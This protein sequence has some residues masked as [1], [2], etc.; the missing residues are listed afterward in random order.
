MGSLMAGWSSPFADP[1]KGFH[2]MCDLLIVSV[3]L[4][5]ICSS[6]YNSWINITCT[7]QLKRNKSLTKEEID[8]FRK[9]HKT[10]NKE[11]ED[12]FNTTL[13]SSPRTPQE[14]DG[15]RKKPFMGFS[16]TADMDKPSKAAGD[17]WTRSN[18]AFLNEPPRDELSDSAHK[19]TAQFHVA[20]LTSKRS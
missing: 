11:E 5:Y 1:E 13:I 16:E 12:D 17:W 7:V 2:Y 4:S 10:N 20:E 8:S 14:T 18:W 3:F 15:R 9:G 6:Q 19:Y